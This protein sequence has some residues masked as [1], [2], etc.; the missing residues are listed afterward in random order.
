[1]PP[2]ADVLQWEQCGKPKSMIA[3]SNKKISIRQVQAQLKDLGY[4]QWEIDL[5]LDGDIDIEGCIR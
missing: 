4:E 1:M 3:F 5:F 2:H